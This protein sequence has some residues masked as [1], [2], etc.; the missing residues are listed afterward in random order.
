MYNEAG[1]WALSISRLHYTCT[2]I[3]CLFYFGDGYATIDIALSNGVK[4]CWNCQCYHGG[5]HHLWIDRGIAIAKV[6]QPQWDRA[7]LVAIQVDQRIPGV[8]PTVEK[9][10]NCHYNQD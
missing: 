1:R 2:S 6:E 9:S 7:R 3:K 5:R 10:E 4:D 8:A